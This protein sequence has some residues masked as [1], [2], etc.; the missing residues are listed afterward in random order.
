MGERIWGGRRARRVVL[1][2]RHSNEGDIAYNQPA[3][4][5]YPTENPW[6]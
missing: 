1:R 5:P 2:G 4:L 6:A 3:S